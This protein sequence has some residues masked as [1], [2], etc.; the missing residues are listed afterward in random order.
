MQKWFSIVTLSAFT[1]LVSGCL[2]KANEE[3]CSA[4]CSNLATL[5]FAKDVKPLADQIKSIEESFTKR[6]VD[7]NTKKES[8]IAELDQQMNE[9]LAA[10]EKDEDKEVIAKEYTPQKE[11]AAKEY[12]AA[13]ADI[14]TKKAAEIASVQERDK[15][16]QE[17]SVKLNEECKVQC[18]KEGI[19]QKIAQCRS[20]APDID[21]YYNRC[22]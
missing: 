21:A 16:R 8:T 20:Q 15:I 1:L 7:A 4:M 14:E 18:Q 22:R 10:A 3:E 9:K 17:E 6:V 12:E 11:A 5:K 2:P 19:L 13:V